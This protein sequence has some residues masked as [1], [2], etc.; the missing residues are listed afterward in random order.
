MP[1]VVPGLTSTGNKTDE[2]TNHLVGKK[3]GDTSDHIVSS[4]LLHPHLRLSPHH[5]TTIMLT[6]PPSPDLC[7][8]GPP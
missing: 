3:I 6:Q 4:S 8:E 5:H 7:E 1:L 2:W